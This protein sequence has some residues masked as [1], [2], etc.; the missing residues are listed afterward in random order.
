[1]ELAINGGVGLQVIQLKL[2]HQSGGLGQL[3]ALQ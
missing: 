1:M 2:A 3:S